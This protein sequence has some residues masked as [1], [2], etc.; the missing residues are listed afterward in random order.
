MSLDLVIVVKLTAIV[1]DTITM[2]LP[3]TESP[4]GSVQQL[5]SDSIG[6]GGVWNKEKTVFTPWHTIG[7][8]DWNLEPAKPED[9]QDAE[10][11]EAIDRLRRH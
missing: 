2:R 8:V 11:K 9:W 4:L 7:R 3:K 1:G 10:F 6:N 5:I